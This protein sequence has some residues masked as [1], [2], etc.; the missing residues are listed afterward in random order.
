MRRHNSVGTTDSQ[1]RILTADGN[2][3][4]IHILNQDWKFLHF[5]DNCNIQGPPGVCVDTRDNLFV[6]EYITCRAKKT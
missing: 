6:A 5:I 1:S 4:C 3:Y 2:N